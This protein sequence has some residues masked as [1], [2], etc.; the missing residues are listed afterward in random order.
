MNK[1]LV[2]Y[3]SASGVTKKVALNIADF[4]DA[5]LYEIMPLDRYTSADLDWTDKQSRSSAEMS[6]IKDWLT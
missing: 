6:D 5:D 1:I 2:S 3:F 4:I